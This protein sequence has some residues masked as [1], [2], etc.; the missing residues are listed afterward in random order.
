MKSFANCWSGDSLQ[1]SYKTKCTLQINH[2]IYVSFVILF[3]NAGVTC[4]ILSEGLAMLFV[5]K[6]NFCHS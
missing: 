4:I 3:H 5:L 6:I 2:E 1:D